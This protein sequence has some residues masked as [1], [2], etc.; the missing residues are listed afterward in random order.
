MAALLVGYCA[1]AVTKR[2]SSASAPT[3]QAPLAGF[4]A[5][6]LL[7]PLLLLFAVSRLEWSQVFIGR[8]LIP[9][10][11]ALALL[12]AVPL[13]ALPTVAGR[14]IA[15]IAMV[16]AALAVHERPHDDF[17]GAVAAVNTFVAGD[18]SVPVLLGTGAIETQDEARLRDPALAEYLA[19]PALYYPVD[20]KLVLLPR[21][22]HG[23]DW[24]RSII[25]KAV[26]GH[27]RFAV[28]EWRGNGARVLDW[29]GASAQRAGFRVQG[30]TFGNVRVGFMDL[31]ESPPSEAASANST[32][33]GH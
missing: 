4:L 10:I 23:D 13:R 14:R 30:E 32:V 27:R 12:Y 28:I 25:E 18:V 16:F 2:E 3:L 22:L 24:E 19:A 29:L 5:L 33:R 8:Y 7:V 9:A 26:Q 21:Q 20:G 11:P 6:W 31:E 15:A 1:S 17:R